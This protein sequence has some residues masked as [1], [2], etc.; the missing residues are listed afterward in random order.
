MGRLIEEELLLLCGRSGDQKKIEI[1]KNS[2]LLS[3]PVI[4]M[5][6]V[7]NPKESLVQEFW[8]E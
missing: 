6:V 3:A 2:F 7:F 8:D 5:E 1:V 4:I